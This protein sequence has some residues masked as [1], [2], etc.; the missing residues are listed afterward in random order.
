[1]CHPAFKGPMAPT[2][3]AFFRSICVHPFL[4]KGEEGRSGNPGFLPPPSF[5]FLPPP[6]RRAT[7]TVSRFHSTCNTPVAGYRLPGRRNRWPRIGQ[8]SPTVP[9]VRS[10]LR[11]QAKV[12]SKPKTNPLLGW[13]F[14]VFFFLRWLPRR[15]GGWPPLLNAG[16]RV[17]SVP[18]KA[19]WSELAARDL[20][21]S[22]LS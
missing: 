15:S 17:L 11:F 19:F 13:G 22:L 18:R 14:F 9:R 2:V 20:G 4:T 12:S 6:S 7:V 21:Y 10:P 1:M 3:S 5:G 16:V 8:T